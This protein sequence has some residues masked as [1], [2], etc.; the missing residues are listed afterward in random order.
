MCIESAAIK[1]DGVYTLTA[2]NNLGETIA[3]ASLKVHCEKPVFSL[4]PSDKVVQD[5]EDIETKIKVDGI[6]RP[7]VQWLKNGKPINTDEIEPNTKT[8]KNRIQTI[9]DAQIASELHIVH[10]GPSDVA[11]YSVVASNIAG[12]TEIKF[13]LAVL[14]LAPIFENKFDKFK[15]IPEGDKLELKCKVDGSPLPRVIWM[16]DN[17]ELLPSEQ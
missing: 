13:R 3:T 10:F 6:P 1:E 9:G 16:H 7:T 17:E 15:E 11:D 12:D 14:E 8:A 2:S 4:K 5:Y